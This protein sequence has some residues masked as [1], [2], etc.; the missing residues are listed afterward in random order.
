MV[1]TIQYE[2]IQWA[3]WY[4]VNYRFLLL[5]N[6]HQMPRIDFVCVREIQYTCYTNYHMQ[7]YHGKLWTWRRHSLIKHWCRFVRPRY[8]CWPRN[9]TSGVELKLYS[10]AKNKRWLHARTVLS[11]HHQGAKT[12]SVCV[13]SWPNKG[14][15]SCV[16]SLFV[17]DA[18]T[19]KWSQLVHC[20]RAMAIRCWWW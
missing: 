18:T 3:V 11:V 7:T 6:C 9:T 2:W 19:T 16:C 17:C 10:V 20:A 5:F 4:K 12:V 8:L 14:N 13:S 1:I 15:Y